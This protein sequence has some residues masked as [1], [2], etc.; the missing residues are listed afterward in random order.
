MP[1]RDEAVALL[2]EHTK[3]EQLIKH[4]LA[5]EAAMRAYARQHGADE[6]LWGNVGLLHDFDYELFPDQ[7]PYAGARI[8]REA[9]WPEELVEGVLAHAEFTGVARDTP[10]KKTIFAVDE[11]SGFVIACALV[12][13]RELSNVTPDRVRKKLKDKSFA[14][15]VVREDI[16]T[17]FAELDRDPDEHVQFVIDSLKPIAGELGLKP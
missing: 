1:S 10:L 11:L 8:L 14:R 5:V 6:E 3:N 12:Y 4:G 2:H 16:H 7:H 13:G 15:G 9:G 17:S